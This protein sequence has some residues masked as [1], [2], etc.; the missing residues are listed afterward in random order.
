MSWIRNHV[1]HHVVPGIFALAQAYRKR[2]KDPAY[3][4]AVSINVVDRKYPVRNLRPASGPVNKELGLI[5][6]ALSSIGYTKYMNRTTRHALWTGS[7]K[8][9]FPRRYDMSSHKQDAIIHTMVKN[10][11]RALRR[12]LR[13]DKRRKLLLLGRDVWLWSVMCHKKGIPHT[14][15]ARIS[16]KVARDAKV[17]KEIVKEW[18]VDT[19]TVLFDTGFAGS[20][21]RCVCNVNRHD[22]INLMLS[23]MR[24]GEHGSEQLFPNHKG[25]RAKALTIEYLPK[26]Q[27]T[28]TVR[29]E[30]AVQWLSEM[31]EFVRAAILTIWFWYNESP[32]WIDQ[33]G[34]RCKVVNCLCASCTLWKK[35]A[36]M[37]G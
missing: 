5:W 24:T 28:G 33:G 15:D 9:I 6:A 14:F 37:P 19:H 25:A 2:Q 8:N 27:K 13:K 26:Y 21:Y 3:W 10:S 7:V 36:K 16:R 11:F 22:P 31:D 29:D 1:R 18:R 30:K 4:H 23:T 12:I 35:E 32:A 34:Q 20:I 17:F